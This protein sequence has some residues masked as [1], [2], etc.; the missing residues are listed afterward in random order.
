VNFTPTPIDGVT[1]VDLDVIPDER[2]F[3]ARSFCADEFGAAGLATTMPQSNVSFNIRRGTLRGLH[4]QS[5]PAAEDKLVRCTSG[6]AFDVAV[7]LREGSPT[8]G[9]WFSAELTVDNHRSLYIPAGCAHGF[10]AL[11]DGT[12]LTYLMSTRYEPSLARA[13]RW[14]DPTIGITWPI[15]PPILSARDATHPYLGA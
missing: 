5:A 10:Q 14:D 6:A 7:D 8:F 3:F 4:Y 9:Q 13:L 1:I 15:L 11:A 12:E 2:G